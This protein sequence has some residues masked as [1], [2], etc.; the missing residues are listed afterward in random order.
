MRIVQLDHIVLNVRDVD[1]ALKFYHGLLGLEALR[2]E[3]FRAGK[4]PFVSVRINA[5]TI[6]DLFPLTGDASGGTGRGDEQQVN[7]NHFCLVTETEDMAALK[8]RF[9]Q[10]G[11]AVERGPSVRWGARGNGSSF[12]VRDPD[13]NVIEMRSYAGLTG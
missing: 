10:E 8:A 1:R 7:L 5:E 12:Y 11:L 6:I 4:V 2:L 9:E 3:A 13:G